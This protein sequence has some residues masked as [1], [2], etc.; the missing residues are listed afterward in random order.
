LGVTQDV[1]V[2]S[3]GQVIHQG[4]SA[5]LLSNPELLSQLIVAH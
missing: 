2:L 3:R 4:Q 5:A 1:L